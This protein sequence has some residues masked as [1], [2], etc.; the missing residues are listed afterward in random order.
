MIGDPRLTRKETHEIGDNQT[1]DPVALQK[2]R[3]DLRS[4]IRVQQLPLFK[5]LLSGGMKFRNLHPD[6]IGDT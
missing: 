2:E 3:W 5:C 1:C 4:K 6:A